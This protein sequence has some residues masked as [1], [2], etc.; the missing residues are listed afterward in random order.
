MRPR[1]QEEFNFIETGAIDWTPMKN[2]FKHL[3]EDHQTLVEEAN[4]E[5]DAIR[6]AASFKM[7]PTHDYT[8]NGA[9]A[10]STIYIHVPFPV[11][12][13]VGIGFT[14]LS[15]GASTKGEIV[16]VGLQVSDAG[17]T[18]VSAYG[19][20]TQDVTGNKQW[21]A[22]DQLMYLSSFVPDGLIQAV[23][24]T[25]NGGAHTFALGTSF[26]KWNLK[27][28]LVTMIKASV[29]QGTAFITGWI[30]VEVT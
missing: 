4:A 23:D 30:L 24:A 2:N 6:L 11:W 17:P 13:V 22:G 15:D 18:D 3:F 19:Q 26:E 20:W 29:A 5:L 14:A 1:P 16:Q 10:A 7:I 8:N 21:V 27:Q 28:G 9:S 25:A 12:R